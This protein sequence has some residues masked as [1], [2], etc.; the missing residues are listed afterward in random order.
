[1]FTRQTLFQ[2]FH[3]NNSPAPKHGICNINDNDTKNKVNTIKRKRK[4][5]LEVLFAG[6]AIHI[7]FR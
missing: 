3:F 2:H 5:D 7:A 4:A 1:M 6:I